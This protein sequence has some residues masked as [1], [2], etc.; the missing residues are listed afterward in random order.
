MYFRH[1]FL[2]VELNKSTVG[3]IPL[4]QLETFFF[5]QIS[6]IRFMQHRR[7]HN[8]TIVFSIDCD[9]YQLVLHLLSVVSRNS[10]SSHS[11]RLTKWTELIDKYWILCDSPAHNLRDFWLSFEWSLFLYLVYTQ[12]HTN[13]IVCEHI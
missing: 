3:Y 11:F 13:K 5:F 9:F 10:M 6:Y 4:F 12:K 7:A 2:C 1:I 8:Y